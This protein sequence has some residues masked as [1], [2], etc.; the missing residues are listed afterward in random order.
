MPKDPN[1]KRYKKQTAFRLDEELLAQIDAFR[2]AHLLPPTRTSVLELALR[3]FL[4][5][6]KPVLKVHKAA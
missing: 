4:N 5:K 1:S 2:N 3:D 6:Q